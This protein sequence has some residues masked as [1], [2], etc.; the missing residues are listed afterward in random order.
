MTLEVDAIKVCDEVILVDF[1][2]F[3]VD[4]ML[5]MN[6][7]RL[8]GGV[9]ISQ[10]GKV[11]FGSSFCGTAVLNKENKDDKEKVNKFEIKKKDHEAVFGVEW[12]V[13]RMLNFVRKAIPTATEK[14]VSAD[15]NGASPMD[16]IYTYPI[17]V[18]G[19][20]KKNLPAKNDK[21]KRFRIGDKVWLKLPNAKCDTK[22]QPALI[23]QD[24]SNQTVE[25]NG[26]PRHVKY[27]RP[28]NDTRSFC[29]VPDVEIE[30]G[31]DTFHGNGE[32][33]REQIEGILETQEE[34]VKA[35]SGPQEFD[36]P[37][38][39]SARERRMPSKY[40]NYYLFDP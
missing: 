27:N 32:N 20:R 22:W 7:I 35:E 2:P 10:L 31:T 21:N 6:S 38:R 36:V 18:K 40:F 3:G 15:K 23:T 30:V 14:N 25:V 24:A 39:R 4:M 34:D 8:L 16:K 29:I 28:Q 19:L 33:H 12:K 5:G 26:I 11:N 13:N 17:G 37:L 9:F 1:R